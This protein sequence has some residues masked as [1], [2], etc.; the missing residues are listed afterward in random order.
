MGAIITNLLPT[1]RPQCPIIF[2]KKPPTPPEPIYTFNHPIFVYLDALDALLCLHVGGVGMVQ[3][4][5]Q[6]KHIR[7]Q[8]LL[9]AESLGFGASLSLQGVLQ[10]VKS[11]DK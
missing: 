10:A 8:L 1:A 3:S 5:L 11:L 4:S 9:E 7:L 2:K 6:V